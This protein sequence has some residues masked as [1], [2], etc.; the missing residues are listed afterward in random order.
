MVYN[1]IIDARINFYHN[2]DN[3]SVDF[4]NNDFTWDF[5]FI[6]KDCVFQNNIF[7]KPDIADYGS[8]NYF[9]N[10]IFSSKS[11]ERGMPVG[12]NNQFEVD[13]ANVYLAGISS[14]PD[15]SA[16][17]PAGLSHDGQYQLKTGCPAV[18]A[19][20]INGTP[21]DCGAFGGAA[22]YILS[23]MPGIPSIYSLTVP[24]KVNI[25]TSTISISLS[26]AAH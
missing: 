6:C 5:E 3:V 12:N 24:A 13:M 22:P 14:L 21:V 19:G 16:D 17:P 26:S 7:H 9:A 25:G 2:I 23:G 4:I 15:V 20:V 18:N 10:N 11:S 8:Y 1:N